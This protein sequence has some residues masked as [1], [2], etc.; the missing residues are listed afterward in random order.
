ML[1]LLIFTTYIDSHVAGDLLSCDREHLKQDQTLLWTCVVGAHH[2]W[3]NNQYAKFEYK[4]ME[5]V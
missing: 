4:G 2:Q 1:S 5:S 3:V